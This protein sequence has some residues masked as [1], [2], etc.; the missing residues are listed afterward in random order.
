[1]KYENVIFGVLAGTLVGGALGVLFAP[2]KGIATR[3]NISDQ[4]RKYSEALESKYNDAVEGL[5]KKF[6]TAKKLG[7]DLALKA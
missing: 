3:K 7:K 2:E 4:S 1:M 6:E 5:T